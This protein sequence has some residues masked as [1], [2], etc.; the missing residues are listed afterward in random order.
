MTIS[1]N[2]GC[3]FTLG[4]KLMYRDVVKVLATLYYDIEEEKEL[5]HKKLWVVL[6]EY[7]L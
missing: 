5:H 2:W 6:V 3:Y 4:T 7:K 1:V